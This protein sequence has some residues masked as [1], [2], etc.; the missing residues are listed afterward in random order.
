MI[1]VA[2]VEDDPEHAERITTFLKRYSDECCRI[3][4]SSCFGSGE[5]FLRNCK[6][7]FDLVLLDIELPGISGMD[8]ARQLREIDRKVLIVFI[9]N[10]A[11][12]AINGYDVHAFDFIVKPVGYYAFAMKLRRAFEC[13]DSACK[14][15]I[16]VT[17]RQ[18]TKQIDAEKLKYVDVMQHTLV[19]HMTDETVSATGTLKS[20]QTS[21]AG[22]PFVLCN[23][24]YLV[25]L[26]FVTQ[27]NGNTVTVGG[28]QLQ[29]SVP[30]KKEFMLALNKFLAVGTDPV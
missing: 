16:W 19:F 8:V 7:G 9:T 5:D 29:I 3:V 25:N 10:L 24:C 28:E 15:K 20:V 14:R 12:Y 17:T 4:E 23:R 13:L 6:S 22:L 2:I 11:Q 30:K 1:R 18:G 26:H 27:V 21:L